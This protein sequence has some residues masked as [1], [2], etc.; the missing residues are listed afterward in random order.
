MAKIKQ[1]PKKIRC[2]QIEFST[3]HE[4]AEQYWDYFLTTELGKI[5]QIIPWDVLCNNFRPQH[6]ESRGKKPEF[7]LQGKIALQFLKS[8]SGVLSMHT[9][10]QRAEIECEI[11]YTE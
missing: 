3:P 1:L 7:D 11:M 2:K 5:Y 9:S 6:R 4:Q 8:N 10:L